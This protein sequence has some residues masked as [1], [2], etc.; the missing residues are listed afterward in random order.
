MTLPYSLQ[1]YV[2][3]KEEFD[4]NVI[5]PDPLQTYILETGD[6]VKLLFAFGFGIPSESMW[7]QIT[8]VIS[9][10]DFKGILVNTPNNDHLQY[11]D[12]I[13]FEGRHISKIDLD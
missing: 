7:V 2:E 5:T 6:H 11:L 3:L 12:E 8:E 1:C 10:G 13:K 4:D 9:P